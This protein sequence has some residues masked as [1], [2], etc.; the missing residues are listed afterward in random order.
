MLPNPMPKPAKKLPQAR[1]EGLMGS[2][3]QSIK[4][5]TKVVRDTQARPLFA[6]INW[7]WAPQQ[8]TSASPQL[9][10]KHLG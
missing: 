2:T 10:P 6:G 9:F 7:I 3:E 8:R 5:M 1:G 4:N